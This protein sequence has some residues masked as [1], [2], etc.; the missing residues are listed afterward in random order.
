LP[1][2]PSCCTI[3]Q[4]FWMKRG[5]TE[6]KFWDMHHRNICPP[7]HDMRINV[8]HTG[9]ATFRQVVRAADR[10][11]D[12]AR[13]PGDAR[14][15]RREPLL[16]RKP[17]GDEP[18]AEEE[19]PGGLPVARGRSTGSSA[20]PADSCANGHPSARRVYEPAAL[21][22]RKR[23]TVRASTGGTVTEFQAVAC[24]DT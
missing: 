18:P 6:F 19:R 10:A 1:G 9:R 21:P 17:V 14:S 5:P 12:G 24:V 2:Q 13:P 3:E 22:E 11:D 8:S 15:R 20:E 16:G 7:L 4:Q 23:V